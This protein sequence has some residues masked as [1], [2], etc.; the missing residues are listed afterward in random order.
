[1][2][3]NLTSPITGG[4]QTG[5]TTPTYT[6]VADNNPSNNGKQWVVTALGGTQAGVTAHTA[7]DPFTISFFKPIAYKVLNFVSS[8][9]FRKPPRN[10]YTVIVRKGV[11]FLSGQPRDILMI[12]TTI[13]IPSGADTLEAANVRAALSALVGSLNQ[14]SAGLGDSCVSNTL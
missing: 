7:A 12:K 13:D 11:A 10:T 2:A 3:V 6:I 5:F 9:V 14:Q 4:A 1:M 8:T